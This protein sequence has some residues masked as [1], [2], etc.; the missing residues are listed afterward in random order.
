MK[1]T[2]TV[3]FTPDELEELN[4]I[5]TGTCLYA[6]GSHYGK[7]L[8]AVRKIQVAAHARPQA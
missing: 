7:A 2:V 1:K 4:R 5:L 3:H 6:N 8:S